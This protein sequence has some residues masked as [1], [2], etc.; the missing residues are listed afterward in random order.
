MLNYNKHKRQ[1]DW[2]FKLTCE[3][4]KLDYG[5]NPL[6]RDRIMKILEKIERKW[7]K[8]IIKL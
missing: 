1:S 6:R 4:A 3:L 5:E 7:D 2:H 8:H